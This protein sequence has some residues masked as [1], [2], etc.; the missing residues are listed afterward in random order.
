M[1]QNTSTIVLY[2]YWLYFTENLIQIKSAVTEFE[3]N[4][5]SILYISCYSIHMPKLYAFEFQFD[6]NFT[7]LGLDFN[8][9]TVFYI[10][11]K[12]DLFE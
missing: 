8:F 7:K 6:R 2:L 10:F 1:V 11:K 9:A 12:E 5:K 3:N 4:T